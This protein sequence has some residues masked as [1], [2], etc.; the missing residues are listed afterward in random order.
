MDL[1]EYQQTYR[2]EDRHWWFISRRR[3]ATALIKQRLGTSNDNRILDVGCGTGGN[4][5]FLRQW[6]TV[7]GIDINLL[8]LNLAH[9]RQSVRLTAA[10]GLALPYPNGTFDLVTAFDVLYHRWIPDDC[11]V[12]R[13]CYRVLRPG[14]WLVVT[15]PA[16]PALWSS[17]DELYQA[18]QRYKLNE[19]HQKLRQAGFNLC[20]CSY[21]NTLLLP[22]AFVVRL[23]LR[24]LPFASDIDLRPLPDPLNQLLLVIR[25]LEV[26]WL[27]W[28]GVLPVGSSLICLAGKSLAGRM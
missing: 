27:Q 13:E 24:R 26:K 20:L 2:L 23:I 22:F 12:I 15:D 5:D 8:P 9:C 11:D 25:D 16:L 21:A 19:M 10:S 17:H 3:L 14:G 7:I 28:G 4:L 6:G 1:P 18:R